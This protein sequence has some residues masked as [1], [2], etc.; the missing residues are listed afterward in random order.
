M[1]T[2]YAYIRADKKN[3][4]D[5]WTHCRHQLKHRKRQVSAPYVAVKNRTMI[6]DRPVDWGGST[7]G[8]FE[9]DTIVGKDG[10]GVIITLVEHNTN[11]TLARKLPQGKNARALAEMVVIMLLPYLG[12]IRFITTDNGGE[13]AEHLISLNGSKPKYS[14][15]ILTPHGKKD[16]SNT[17]TSSSGSI[18]PRVLTSITSLTKC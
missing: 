6:D 10:K 14:L 2:I 16:V 7:P 8:D 4:G 3:G 11:F 13:F 18:S 1:E 12:K 5:L 9:M 15:H 17:I